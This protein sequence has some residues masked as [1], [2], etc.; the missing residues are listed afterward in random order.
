M[1]RV[2]L[3]FQERPAQATGDGVVTHLVPHVLA[4]TAQATW[5]Q[6][7]CVVRS[8]FGGT[9]DAVQTQ[10]SFEDARRVLARTGARLGHD[11][12]RDVAR[13][14][15]GTVALDQ[16]DQNGQQKTDDHRMDQH[17]TNLEC[18]LQI[19]YIFFRFQVQ[20]GL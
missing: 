20:V 7:L 6:P 4:G 14:G 2:F 11:G 17:F 5:G 19:C 12:V 10:S 8:V 16:H 1:F 18:H 3:V 13:D 9:W 15:L